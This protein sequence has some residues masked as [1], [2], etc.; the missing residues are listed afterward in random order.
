MCI[1]YVISFYF[2]AIYLRSVQLNI[3]FFYILHIS[4]AN[5]TLAI[6]SFTLPVIH[7]LNL[8]HVTFLIPSHHTQWI[9]S[10]CA[11]VYKSLYLINSA[12]CAYLL[13]AESRGGCR[14]QANV[15]QRIVCGRRDYVADIKLLGKRDWVGLSMLWVVARNWRWWHLFVS[16]LLL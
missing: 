15:F 2:K 13:R 5:S 16:C 6:S 3:F 14:L 4:L 1:L 8:T 10:V 12:F 11:R 7:I 9:I